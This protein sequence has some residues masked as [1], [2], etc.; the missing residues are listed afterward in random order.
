MASR[1]KKHSGRKVSRPAPGHQLKV[2]LAA[3]FVLGFLILSLVL[4]SHL[5]KILSPSPAPAPMV[6][7]QQQLLD[8]LRVELE[9]ALLR[10]GAVLERVE[11]GEK[12]R[13]LRFEAR[14]EFPS[15]EILAGLS[16]RLERISDDFRLDSR[17][18]GG[19][20]RVCRRDAVWALLLFQRRS[21][22]PPDTGAPKLAIIMDDLGSDMG[23]ARALL[24]IDLPVTLSIM[25]GT[26]NASQV[27][28]LAHRRG[29]EVMIHMPMEP[30]SYP[31]TDPGSDALLVGYS[32]A[33]IRR[34]FQGYLER[35]PYAV[36]GNNHMG[37]R[38][39]ESREGMATVVA[40]MK[41]ADLFFVDSLTTG[42]SVAFD[43]ARKAGV[44]AA[45]RDVFLDN[46]QDVEKISQQLQR[47]AALA[48]K[49]GSAVG[50]CHPHP[51]TLEALRGA[52]EFLRGQGI[53]VVPVSRL[54]VR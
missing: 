43:E 1:K 17:P 44:P 45:L 49:R 5:R 25:P 28:T 30:L 22:D 20:V 8:D 26:A 50:L 31:E 48:V 41:K 47:L 6:A 18:E 33:E 2:L 10:S 40:E 54:L 36:G 37:S 32:A 7:T 51:Q 23:F 24:A 35:V 38:F 15:P 4:L 16:R 53:E 13:A 11:A 14:G 27:A 52:P 21:G 42:H 3:L 9:S 34:R 12:G 46:V 19:E 39:T 29:R